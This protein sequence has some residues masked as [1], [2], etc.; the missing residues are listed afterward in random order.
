MIEFAL[1][2]SYKMSEDKPFGDVQKGVFSS[3]SPYLTSAGV[4]LNNVSDAM[5]FNLLHEGIHIG[6]IIALKKALKG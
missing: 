2:Q 3:Y 5:A 1:K 4:T 6:S